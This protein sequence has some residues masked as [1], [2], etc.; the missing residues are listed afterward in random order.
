MNSR[1][2]VLECI[3]HRKPDRPPIFATLTPQ[4]AQRLAHELNLPAEPPLDSLLSTRISHSKLLTALGNDCVGIA[5]CAPADKLTSTDENGIITN[6][7]GM[8][9]K[10]VD[11]YNE[12]YEYPLA[13]VQSVEEVEAYPFPDPLARGRFD[14]AKEAVEIYAQDYAIVADLETSIFETAWYL[15]GLEKFLMDLTTGAAYINVLLNKIQ[16]INT[17][18]GKQLIKLGADI[19][20]A[21]DDFGSQTGMIM[22]PQQWRSI[23]KPRIKAMFDEFRAVNPNIKIAWHS[24]GSIT[25]IIPDF[26]EI[27]LDLLNPIQPLSAG[28][29][30]EFL[31]KEYGN[32]LVFFGG[33]DVQNLLPYK[34]PAE[35]RS[36]VQRLID[37]LGKNGG[38]I[39]APAHNIQDDTPT[40]NIIALFEAVKEYRGYR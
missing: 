2:R 4:V 34:S 39:V 5:A 36:E 20:W 9:F 27:G 32:E 12:F 16:A 23:F 17:E 25:P 28:M 6:E 21:G 8:R 1:E 31:A 10:N 13:G 33:I 14:A 37:I 24:C 40:E 30:P 26:I 3:N 38:Y 7:W 29:E 19:I 11:L 15:V 35:I 22:S 18:I